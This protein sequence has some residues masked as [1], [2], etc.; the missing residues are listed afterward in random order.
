M[1]FR[2]S[3]FNIGILLIISGSIGAGIILFEANKSEE[4][5]HLDNSDVV[6]LPIKIDG[7]GIGFYLI[8]SGNYQNNI[9]A[10]VVDSHGNFLDIRKITNKITVDYFRFEHSDQITLEITNLSDKPVQLSVTIG[11]TRVQEIM[12]PAILIFLG[13]LILVFSGYKKLHNYITEHPDENNS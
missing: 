2:I 12:Y 6:T 5:F 1:K 8:S 4:N 11:D 3:L 13:A 10:K 9:L 7:N